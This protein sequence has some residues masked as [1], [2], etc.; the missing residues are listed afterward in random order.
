VL[1]VSLLG[2]EN[3]STTHGSNIEPSRLMPQ[4]PLITSSS[5]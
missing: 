1:V 2:G 4:F 5:N 3:L